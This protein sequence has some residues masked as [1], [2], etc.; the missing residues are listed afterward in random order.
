M[1]VG[2]QIVRRV[3]LSVPEEMDVKA[4]RIILFGSRTREEHDKHGDRDFLIVIDLKQ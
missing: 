4:K 2:K 1:N 3:I